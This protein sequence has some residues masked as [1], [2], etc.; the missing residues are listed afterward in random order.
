MAARMTAGYSGKPLVAKLG[1]KARERWLLVNA[2]RGF[3]AELEPLPD[4]AA[5]IRT[6]RAGVYGTILFVKAR[7][8]LERSVER[9]QGSIAEGGALWVAWPK[10]ASGV[11]TDVT[12]D[13]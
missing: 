12:E 2:P 9:V 1:V 5:L 11:A 7:A 3:E 8:M 10:K 13:A 4:G 6:S